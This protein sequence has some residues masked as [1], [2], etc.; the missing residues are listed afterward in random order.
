MAA[1]EVIPLGY[2]SDTLAHGAPALAVTVAL[3]AALIFSAGGFAYLIDARTQREAQDRIARMALTDLLTG[4]PNRAAFIAELRTR[5]G[6]AQF[7]CRFA[8]IAFEIAGMG[9]INQQF[10]A[11]IADAVVRAIAC[12]V[13]EA[14]KLGTTRE[15]ALKRSMRPWHGS[16]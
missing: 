10:G 9:A 4:L 16:C 2:S 13:L 5:V 7:D 12:R 15:N 14:R 8:V 3:V 6:S 1:M 11:S